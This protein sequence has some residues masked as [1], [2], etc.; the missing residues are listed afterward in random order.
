MAK[1]SDMAKEAGGSTIVGISSVMVH[2]D[3]NIFPFPLSI[4][5]DL[6][7]LFISFYFN[8]N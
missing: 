8:F 4:F 3:T 5:L 1:V 6:I 2:L 7:F